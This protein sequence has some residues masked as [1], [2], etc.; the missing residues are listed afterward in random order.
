MRKKAKQYLSALEE[1][2]KVEET[3]AFSFEWTIKSH[4]TCPKRIA[5]H[6]MYILFLYDAIE[7]HY[8]CDKIMFELGFFDTD[9]MPFNKCGY[10]TM[11]VPSK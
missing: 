11:C 9:W 7:T 6:W 3:S 8:W 5:Y 4:F 10:N 2:G 1:G